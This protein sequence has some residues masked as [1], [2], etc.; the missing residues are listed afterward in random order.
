M[1]N[2]IFL[3]LSTASLL[4]VNAQKKVV[5]EE[6]EIIV[7]TFPEG[8][9]KNFD[10][11]KV[12]T[13]KIN[14]EKAKEQK[15]TVEIDGNNIKVNGK[16]ISELKDVDVK[17]GESRMMINGRNINWTDGQGRNILSVIPGQNLRSVQMPKG[18]PKAMLGIMM[19]T[20]D[21]GV[22]VS[23]ITEG[24]GADKAGLKEGDIINKLDDKEIKNMMDITKYIASKKPNDEVSVNYTRNGKTQTAKVKLTARAA[25]TI[26]AF[27]H[28]DEMPFPEGGSLNNIQDF[29]FNLDGNFD[30]PNIEVF[31]DQNWNTKKPKL[32]LKI[33]ETEDSKGVTVTEVTAESVAAKAGILKDDIITKINGESITNV[34]IAKSALANIA[35]QPA[36]ITVS[37]NGKEQTIE[38]KLPKKLKSTNL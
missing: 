25:T 8:K 9:R 13:I 35:N 22:A 4:Q 18:E 21:N 17:I 33:T 30:M 14:G 28:F 6:K 32:G 31:K 1:K 7:D 15:Y 34:D 26:S 24:S 37:R 36:K 20:N 12:V 10:N 29:K 27:G 11:S 38:V 23:G 16:D 3:L 2:L 5:I 19:E